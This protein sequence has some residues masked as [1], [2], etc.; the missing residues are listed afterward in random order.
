MP[1]HAPRAPAF[2]CAD[3][4]SCFSCD[5]LWARGNFP[6]PQ[7]F[8]KPSAGCNAVAAAMGRRTLSGVSAFQGKGMVVEQPSPC[9]AQVA[10]AAHPAVLQLDGGP[11]PPQ[12]NLQLL[13]SGPRSRRCE[14]S[15]CHE[16]PSQHP[17]PPFV[18]RSR[19]SPAVPS[20]RW[21]GGRG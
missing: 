20:L 10:R 1:P 9:T 17:G 6:S 14:A 7:L 11:A 3:L 8:P 16:N 2:P 4:P 21:R 12:E 15:C 5:V 19:S 13:E 18:G